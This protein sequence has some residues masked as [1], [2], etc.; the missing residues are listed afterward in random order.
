VELTPCEGKKYCLVIVD[1]FSK[2]VEVFPTKAADSA[3]V[4]K[5]LITEI[6][7]RWGIPKK[8]SSDNGSHFVNQAIQQLSQ[9]VGINLHTHCAYH[10]QSGGAAPYRLLVEGLC[11][12]AREAFP[13]VRDWTAV[14]DVKQRKGEKVIDLL[15]WLETVFQTHGGMAVP[16]DRREQTPYKDAITHALLDALDESLSPFIKRHCTGHEGAFQSEGRTVPL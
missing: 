8:L 5:A 15:D 2:W 9:Y 3:A 16:M 14:R 13:L 6:I 10:P 4:A 11:Q 7:P 1:M 12:R